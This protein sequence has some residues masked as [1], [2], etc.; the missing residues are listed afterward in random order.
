[1]GMLEQNM[2]I[3]EVRGLIIKDLP[4]SNMVLL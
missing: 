4:H 3:K 2:P 1:M